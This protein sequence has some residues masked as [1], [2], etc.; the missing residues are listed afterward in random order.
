MSFWRYEMTISTYPRPGYPIVPTMLQEFL[1]PTLRTVDENHKHASAS[2]R[3]EIGEKVILALRGEVSNIRERIGGQRLPAPPPSLDLTDLALENRTHNCLKYLGADRDLQLLG[4]FTIKNLLATKNF[5]IKSLVDLLTTLEF[6]GTQDWAGQSSGKRLEPDSDTLS[7]KDIRNILESRCNPLEFR[8]RRLPPLPDNLNLKKLDLRN[9]T[10]NCLENAGFIERPGALSEQSIAALFSLKSFGKHTFFDLLGVL[11]PYFYSPE[12]VEE[13]K[14]DAALGLLTEARLLAN[15][16]AAEVI[17]PD[18]PRLGR[19]LRAISPDAQNALEAAESLT[20]GSFVPRNPSTTLAN[21]RRLSEEIETLTQMKLEDE[22]NS[23]LVKAKPRDAEMFSRR[24]GLDGDVT[25]TLQEIGIRFGMTRERVR[26]ICDKVGQFFSGSSPFVP[27]TDRALDLVVKR[28][29][30]IADEIEQEFVK[31]GIAN[32][33]FRLEA[34]QSAAQLLQR[35]LLFS[36]S[37]VG[38]VRTAVAMDTQ[39]SPAK[40]LRLARKLTRHWGALTMEELGVQ[41]AEKYG[42]PTDLVFQII[43]R[44]G[45]FKWLDQET[46]WFWLTRHLQNRI[47]NRIKKILSIS[48]RVEIGELRDGVRRN[49]RMAGTAPPKRVLLEICRQLPWCEVEGALI[50]SNVAFKLDEVLSD[51]ELVF[52]TT[53]K[54]NGPAMQRERLEEFCLARGMAHSTFYVY[55]GYSPIIVRHARGV[56]GLRGVDVPVGLVESLRPTI[57]R[58]RVTKDGGWM[59][60]GKLWIGYQLSES[61]VNNGVVSIPSSLIQFVSGQFSLR[62]IDGTVV[63]TLATNQSS[64]WGLGPLFRRRGVEGD[65]YLVLVFDA[66][67]RTAIAHLGDEGLL[68]EFQTGVAS[69][70]DNDSSEFSE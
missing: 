56:Y 40:V 15:M 6:V 1:P 3:S 48:G 28:L 67:N 39:D 18:D 43:T 31:D 46:G 5:G 68:E 32:K 58:G 17:L 64:A 54:A 44:Q 21:I 60:D 51:V 61:T 29:P 27:A 66:T 49:H 53:L 55:L 34:L 33:M 42:L 20:R 7:A 70:A 63:G 62:T 65:D 47:T 2:E 19:L 12:G 50:K 10:Y 26:Q 11:E 22:L 69:P 41:V 45:D 23:I 14:P 9:R 52:A 57:Q 13:Q 35:E 59:Q 16:S 8:Q 36:I 38:G 37:D 30:A 4:L 24:Y 25:N